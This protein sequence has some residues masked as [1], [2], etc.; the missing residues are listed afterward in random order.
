MCVA[1]LPLRHTSLATRL[2]PALSTT[3]RT[4][5]RAVT[6]KPLQDA[7][8][9]ALAQQARANQAYQHLHAQL[10]GQ[11]PFGW[12]L[13]VVNEILSDSVYQHPACLLSFLAPILETYHQQH[14]LTAIYLVAPPSW[15]EQV[16]RIGQVEASALPGGTQ[17]W[18]SCLHLISSSQPAQHKSWRLGIQKNDAHPT[19]RTV[20]IC[21]LPPSHGADTLAQMKYWLDQAQPQTLFFCVRPQQAASHASPAAIRTTLTLTDA[22]EGP[23]LIWQCIKRRSLV[24]LAPILIP[25]PA[26]TP[27]SAAALALGPFN[28]MSSQRRINQNQR[29]TRL[30]LPQQTRIRHHQP[31]PIAPT[32][33]LPLGRIPHLSRTWRV[34]A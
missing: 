15:I 18:L 27:T 11:G 1:P 6:S 12:P 24:Q 21:V 32:R 31:L 2:S 22:D 5:P 14:A 3:L 26:C 28:A 8:V 10:P 25:L 33:A 29:Q 20:V 16:E 9:A 30:C 34:A 17:T 4:T 13:G 23:V 19:Q 7:G